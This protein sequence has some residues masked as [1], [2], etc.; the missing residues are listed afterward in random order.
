MLF[1][2]T[3]SHHLSLRPV[4]V[5]TRLASRPAATVSGWLCRVRRY[6]VNALGGGQMVVNLEWPPADGQ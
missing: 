5:R 6:A 1:R 3:T 4:T 2:S